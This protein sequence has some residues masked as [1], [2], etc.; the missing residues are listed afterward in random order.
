M[1]YYRVERGDGYLPK[2]VGDIKIFETKEKALIAYRDDVLQTLKEC[3]KR[4][5]TMRSTYIQVFD[6]VNAELEKLKK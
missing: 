3:N 6:W 5:E 2:I 1:I 4:A